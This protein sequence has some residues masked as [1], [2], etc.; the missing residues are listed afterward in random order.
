[1]A[2]N[3]DP[4]LVNKRTIAILHSDPVCSV[5]GAEA[6]PIPSGVKARTV[7]EVTRA[8]KGQIE[9]HFVDFWV[10]GEVT[11]FKKHPPSGHM[12]FTLKDAGSVLP[13]I[14]KVGFNRRM[15]CEP[16]DGMQVICFG[17]LVVF[18]QKG[19]YQLEVQ[20]FEP[21]GIG[22]AELA[23]QQLTAEL[24]AKGY[25]DPARRR[26]MPVFPK[27]VALVTSSSGAAVRDMIES[28]LQRWPLTGIVVRDCRVQGPTAPQ[29]LADSLRLL[30]RRHEAGTLTLCA[31]VLG[32]GGGPTA[33]LSAFNEE[34]VADAIFASS[35]PIISAVGHETDVTIADRVA[36]FRALTPTAAIV[37]LTQRSRDD[38]ES[39]LGAIRDRLGDAMAS[40][41]QHARQ[42]VE[43][44]A[45]RPGLRRPMDR[46]RAAGQLIDERRVR[47]TRAGERMLARGDEKLASAASQLQALSP[48]NVLTR[49]YSLTQRGDGA[50]L[51]SPSEVAVGEVIETRL[52]EGTILSRVLGPNPPTPDPTHGQ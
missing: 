6:M 8:V 27:F 29:A 46:Y 20:E 52:A 36:D 37:A 10:A 26:P 47:L 15:K 1:M 11:N 23:L 13:C 18:E 33:D 34:I 28:L 2:F 25:F 43:Q 35:V 39:E 40:R 3:R 19:I 45:D 49:G 16:R 24:S 14:F 12:Y 51:R 41:I 4:R 5:R 17:G 31:I 32:R 50:L 22:A 30:S 7:T 42:M 48:L 38:V 9:E 44:L 21:K